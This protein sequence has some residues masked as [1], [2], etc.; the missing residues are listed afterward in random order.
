MIVTNDHEWLWRCWWWL[1]E[2]IVLDLSCRVHQIVHSGWSRF[3]GG[4]RPAVPKLMRV[5]YHL[6]ERVELSED[7]IVAED[8]SYRLGG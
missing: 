6:K 4:S 5:D 7:A 3:H 2:A 8:L 1:L